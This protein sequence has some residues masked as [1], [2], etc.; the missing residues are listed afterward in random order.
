MASRRRCLAR[1]CTP[2]E[3]RK[4]TATDRYRSF[5]A[6]IGLSADT[7]RR[8]VAVP[9]DG[10]KLDLQAEL[11]VSRRDL[12]RRGA[13][14][15]GALLWVAP[16]IQSLTP[17]AYANTVSEQADTCCS[18]GKRKPVKC[19]Q[20]HL[21]EQVCIDFCGSFGVFE[22]AEGKVCGSKNECVPI[23]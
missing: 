11:G 23:G 21:T 6:S 12:I 14:V 5:Q 10:K 8:G 22:Y 2:G 16:A 1:T 19:A 17:P 9:D 3:R 18:C 13:V 7:T 4:D 20:D 15:G